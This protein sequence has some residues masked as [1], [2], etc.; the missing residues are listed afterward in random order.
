MRL[1]IICGPDVTYVENDCD[2][3][4]FY[5]KY[6]SSS[7]AKEQRVR[8]AT[9]SAHYNNIPYTVRNSNTSGFQHVRQ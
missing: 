4:C 8:V 1:S 3:G 9:R 5:V 7:T 2:N 6:E